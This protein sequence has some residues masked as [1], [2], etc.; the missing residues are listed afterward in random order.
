M[1]HSDLEAKLR[2]VPVPSRSED[3]W[4]AFPRQVRAQLRRPAPV[5]RTVGEVWLPRLA[6]G[7]GIAFACLAVSL[8]VWFAPVELQH[9]TPAAMLKSGRPFR[10]LAHISNRLR[11][12][13][14]DEH[15]LNYLVADQE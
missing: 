6:W 5:R 9:A 11:V 2:S 14:Q 4:D 1:N 3:Y 10:E 15:G 12:L 7:G 8:S 13:L